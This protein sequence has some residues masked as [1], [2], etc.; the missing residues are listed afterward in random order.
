MSFQVGEQVVF[1]YEVG[2][3]I[4]RKIDGNKFIIEDES[5]FERPFELSF[6]AKKHLGKAKTN[7]SLDAVIAEKEGYSKRKTTHRALKK[8]PD[9]WEIDLHFEEISPSNANLTNTE[10]LYKQLAFFKRSYFQAREKKMRRI[11]IIHGVGKGVLRQEIREF[12]LGQEGAVEFLD[13][14]YQEYGFGATQVEL[15]YKY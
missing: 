10:I 9:L 1:L 5:G 4:V 13:G 7:H 2:G 14:S 8:L 12:L 3:G 6:L 11:V 15:R